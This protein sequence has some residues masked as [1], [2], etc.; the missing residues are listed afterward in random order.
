MSAIVNE[1]LPIIEAIRITSDSTFDFAG[2]TPNA[3][4]GLDRVSQ[5]RDVLYSNC[6]CTK[7]PH[8]PFAAGSENDTLVLDLS[9]A[10]TGQDRWVPGWEILSVAA[11]GR[12]RARKNDWERDFWPGEFLS[13]EGPGVAPRAGMNVSAYFPKESAVMQPGF[14]FAFGNTEEEIYGYGEVVRFY[15]AIQDG[16]AAELTRYLTARLNRFQVP[17]RFKLPLQRYSYNRLDAAVLYVNKRFY[18]ISALLVAEAH[19]TVRRTLW[20]DNPL[21]TK[22]LAPGLGLAEDP[23]TGESFGMH[24]CRIFSEGV[25]S[26]HASGQHGSYERLTEVERRF[27]TYG[28]SLERPYLNHGSA[29]CYDFEFTRSAHA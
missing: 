11:N 16:G 25:W 6:F 10:N 2:R 27:Q 22:T 4:A 7:Y 9:A 23:D 21:F 19:E 17:F 14:Y 20:P 15:W 28:I 26:A 8:G 1:L 13:V 24:R 3:Q 5:L 12:V 18:Q 29:D